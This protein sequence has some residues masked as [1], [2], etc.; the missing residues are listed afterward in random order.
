MGSSALR[1][2]QSSLGL[3]A[4]EPGV[5]IGFHG[6]SRVVSLPKAR[7]QRQKK[8]S[9]DAFRWDVEFT[10]DGISPHVHWSDISKIRLSQRTHDN[11]R[12]TYSIITCEAICLEQIRT[13]LIEDN[14]Q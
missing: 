4:P 6:E 7:I 2:R 13:N 8:S 9:T 3:F 14:R 12:M 11:K 10:L 5:L 1:Q